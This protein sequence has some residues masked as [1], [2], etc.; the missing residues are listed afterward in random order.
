MPEP[1]D[2]S[3]FA[4][5]ELRVSNLQSGT[6]SGPAGSPSSRTGPERDAAA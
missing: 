5:G 6:F 1:L 3:R 2:R 4:L